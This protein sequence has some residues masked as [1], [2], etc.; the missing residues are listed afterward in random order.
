VSLGLFIV[1]GLIVALGTMDGLPIVP[2][3]G[4]LVTLFLGLEAR[5][6]HIAFLR[7]RGWHEWGLVD[8]TSVDEALLIYHLRSNPDGTQS[9]DLGAKQRNIS[10]EKAAAGSYGACAS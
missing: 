4:F 3:I 2:L 8:A 1:S 10:R 7:R 5:A 6:M 9:N